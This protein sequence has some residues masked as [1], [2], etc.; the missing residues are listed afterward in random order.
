MFDRARWLQCSLLSQVCLEGRCAKAMT[1]QSGLAALASYDASSSSSNSSNSHSSNSHSNSN[2]E[3]DKKHEEHLQSDLPNLPNPGVSRAFRAFKRFDAGA[4][5]HGSQ[6]VGLADELSDVDILSSKP[7]HQLL[8]ALRNEK[9]PSFELSEAV[10]SA[11]IPRIIMRHKRTGRTLDVVEASRDPWAQAKDDMICRWL[12]LGPNVRDFAL[13]I[14]AFARASQGQ[15]PREQG[16]PN[17]FLFLLTGFWFLSTQHGL[18]PNQSTDSPSPCTK[19]IC[20]E[21][22]SDLFRGEGAHLLVWLRAGSRALKFAMTAR[23]A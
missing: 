21:S 17:T 3:E 10:M 23:M 13:R 8:K 12:Q 16:Y 20:R 18:K 9:L 19:R 5:L 4:V 7:V 6:A 1:A 15:L 14:K 2:A 11:R 22:S